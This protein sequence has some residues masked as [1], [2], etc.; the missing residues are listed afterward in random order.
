MNPTETA[1]SRPRVRPWIRGLALVAFPLLAVAAAHVLWN[2][3]EA[4]RLHHELELIRMRGEPTTYQQAA[5]TPLIQDAEKHAGRYYLAAAILA[6]PTAP[7]LN[8]YGH[9]GPIRSWL[10]GLTPEPAFPPIADAT[11]RF[12]RDWDQAYILVDKASTLVF[13]GFPPGI[14]YNYQTAGL[15]NLSRVLAIRTVDRALAG[16]G[17][18]AVASATSAVRLNRA[19]RTTRWLR[20]PGREIATVL[21]LSR[22]SERALADLESALRLEDNPDAS[23]EWFI[24]ERARYIDDMSSARNMPL[25]L[26]PWRTHELV[27]TLRTWARLLE[28][29]RR[30]WPE[31]ARIG[32]QVLNE[33]WPDRRAP[34]SFRRSDSPAWL[35][36]MESIWPYALVADRCERVA[37]AIE[38]YRR[39]HADALPATLQALVP[40]FLDSVPADPLSGR[41]LLYRADA[42]AYVVYSVGL[43]GHDDGGTLAREAPAAAQRVAAGPDSGIRVLLR[44]AV[45]APSLAEQN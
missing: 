27:G 9:L 20:I 5:P 35:V 39:A 14:Q 11:A 33:Y 38:R 1:P 13:R 19:L 12:V 32:D 7:I 2:Y 34:A 43:D 29:A 10:T 3:V 18:G 41:D 22:P 4:S 24:A 23:T 28:T 25:V 37:V 17:D 26:R 8:V 16:D 15:S 36:F 30:P 40:A 42:G 6:L 45:A 21:S 44:R 31:R